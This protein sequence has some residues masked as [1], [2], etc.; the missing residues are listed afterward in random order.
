[1]TRTGPDTFTSSLS[2][3][4][5]PVELATDGNTLHI[6]Y[7]LGRFTTRHQRLGAPARRRTVL[8]LATVRV[9]GVPVARLTE[10]ITRAMPRA[11][12]EL[13]NRRPPIAECNSRERRAGGTQTPKP[14]P[15]REAYA[16]SRFA[17]RS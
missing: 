17:P 15:R 11:V 13:A 6:R 5:G 8:N 9:L 1:M 14:D 16:P 3:A 12:D 2:D 4:A 7:R 10:T